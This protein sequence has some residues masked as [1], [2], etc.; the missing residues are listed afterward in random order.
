MD[1]GRKL[2]E[3]VLVLTAQPNDGVHLTANQHASYREPMWFQ[4]CMRGG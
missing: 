1:G 2:F 4:G 3:S